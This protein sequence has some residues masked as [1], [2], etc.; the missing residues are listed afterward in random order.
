[1]TKRVLAPEGKIRAETDK[2]IPKGCMP[3]IGRPA[4]HGVHLPDLSGEEHTIAVIGQKGIFHLM[5]G[6]KVTRPAHADGGAVIPVAPG[7]VIRIPEL[8][9][10]GVIAVFPRRHLG[11]AFKT[12]RLGRD[13]PM[14]AILA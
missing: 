11:V 6:L 14:D 4:Q 12:D 7:N 5:K 9:Y 8:A 3:R 13:I 1:M 2:N 10:P